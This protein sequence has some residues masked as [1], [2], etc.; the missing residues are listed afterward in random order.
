[1]VRR[2]G[3][4]RAQPGLVRIEGRVKRKRQ[5]L[6]P[7]RARAFFTGGE[8]C[9]LRVEPTPTVGFTISRDIAR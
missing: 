4:E 6:D 9:G 1:M 5:V 3:G 8:W 7:R 2:A